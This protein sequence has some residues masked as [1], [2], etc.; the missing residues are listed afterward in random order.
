[1]NTEIYNN[2]LPKRIYVFFQSIVKLDKDNKLDIEFISLLEAIK[3]NVDCKNF[4][5][6][7]F[8]GYLIFIVKFMA[9]IRDYEYGYGNMDIF[10]KLLYSLYSVF[11]NVALKL[12]ENCFSIEKKLL[13]GSWKDI[14]YICNYVKTKTQNP[15]HPLINKAVDLVVTELKSDSKK[16]NEKLS[17]VAKWI[18]REKSK[19]GWLFDIISRRYYNFYFYRASNKFQEEMAFSKA[20]RNLRKTCTRLNLKIGVLE[21][22]LC[23]KLQINTSILT[24][25]NIS[26]YLSHL[27]ER[28]ID[29]NKLKDSQTMHWQNIIFQAWK[30]CDIS[31]KSNENEILNLQWQKI[32]NTI[33]PLINIL[34]IIDCSFEMGID[35]YI[36]SIGLAILIANKSNLGKRIV[37]INNK[38]TWI[39][40]ENCS[41]LIDKL[42]LI[43]SKTQMINSDLNSGYQS[44]CREIFSLGDKNIIIKDLNLLVLTNGINTDI[45]EV[46]KDSIHVKTILWFM[47]GNNKTIANCIPNLAIISGDCKNYINFF[48]EKKG[49]KM[50]IQLSE[51]ILFVKNFSKILMKP[52]FLQLENIVHNGFEVVV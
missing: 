27:I 24:K 37:L 3:I 9:L 50:S 17:L 2:L 47:E 6:N 48:W 5:Q 11:P 22:K 28:G 49:N 18:P 31:E 38:F 45:F 34:P 1:M 30:K 29:L 32:E 35:N 25:K 33:S 46:F 7:L 41:N 21:N 39:S 15:F 51:D 43:K 4:Y 8:L 23:N 19:F 26:H 40:F 42:K 36:R 20:R 14:K 16:T 13:I 52:K 10:I 44:L 12:L